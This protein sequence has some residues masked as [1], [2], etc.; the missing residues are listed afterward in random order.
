[1]FAA[2]AIVCGLCAALLVTATVL[3]FLRQNARSKAKLQGLSD[4]TE[5]SK[6]YQVRKLSL[7]LFGCFI[8]EFMKAHIDTLKRCDETTKSAR[9]FA[10]LAFNQTGWN[11]AVA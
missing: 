5:A 3:F 6:D 4:D 9:V 11:L 1:M 2:A 8:I 10:L 7:I